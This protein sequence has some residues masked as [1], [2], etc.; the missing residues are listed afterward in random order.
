MRLKLWPFHCALCAQLPANV[1]QLHTTAEHF[2]FRLILSCGGWSFISGR[3]VYQEAQDRDT[4][5]RNT[6]HHN[7]SSTS[8]DIADG[9]GS[10]H[11]VSLVVTGAAAAMT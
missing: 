9:Y 10:K 5:K 6:A 3:L 8:Y 1:S 7:G 4:Q 2:T 11:I